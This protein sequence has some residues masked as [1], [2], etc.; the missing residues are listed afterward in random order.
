MAPSPRIDRERIGF[1]GFSRGGYTG[2]AVIG[3]KLNFRRG[4]EACSQR[5]DLDF[6]SLYQGH[7]TPHREPTLDARIKAAV[8]AD[9]ALTFLF[10]ENDLKEVAVPVQLWSSRLGGAGVSLENIAAIDRKLGFKSE[11][12]LVQNAVHWAFLAP[13]PAEFNPRNCVD[14]PGFDRTAFHRELNA[15]VLSFFRSHLPATKRP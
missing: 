13:C 3:G 1:F 8:I 15:A 10:G 5:P 11:F 14:P 2:L 9:P 12:H 7:E 6:C 4:L